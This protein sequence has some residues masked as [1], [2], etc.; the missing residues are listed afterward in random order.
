MGVPQIWELLRPYIK[1]KRLPLKC[2]VSD[3]KKDNGR[4]P[5]I[6]IDGYSWIF[7]CGFLLNQDQDVSNKYAGY[8]T[9]PKAL[10]N[11]LSRLK[12]FLSLD[13][14]FILVFDGNMKPWFKN[15]YKNSGEETTTDTEYAKDYSVTWDE[16][17]QAHQLL[18]SC[19]E[20]DANNPTPS[21]MKIIKYILDEMKISYIEAC[22]EG[23]AQCAWLQKHNYVDYVLSND[24]DTLIFGCSKMLRNY[25]KSWEDVG[26]TGVGNHR[27]DRKRDNKETFVTIVDIEEID[28]CAEERYNWWSLLFFSV[29][30][31]ADYNKGV[32]G[33]GKSKS[34]KLAQLT[35][36]DFAIQFHDIFN[37]I[38]SSSKERLIEYEQ[39]KKRL[40]DYC[41]SHSVELF[42]RNYK[43]LLQEDMQ[44]WPSDTAIMYYF[45]PFLIPDLDEGVMDL[46]NVN[47]SGSPSYENIDFAN[48]KNYLSAF[49]LPGVTDFERWFFE[50]LQESF[51]LRH[52]LINEKDSEKYMKITEEKIVYFSE[53]RFQSICWKVRYNPYIKSLSELSGRLNAK[54]A[55]SPRKRSPTKRQLESEEHWYG[56]WVPKGLIPGSHSLVKRF[57]ERR[58]IEQENQSRTKFSPKKSLKTHSQKNT[59][60]GFLMCHSSPVQDINNLN[61]IK[62]PLLQTVKKRLFVEQEDDFEDH[63]EHEGSSLIILEEIDVSKNDT[64]P[65]KQTW[66]LTQEYEEIHSDNEESPI[67]KQRLHG[68]A[69]V[70]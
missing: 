16:H 14:S 63:S 29:L 4:S 36:P 60:D 55:S 52:L 61:T 69:D 51:I 38:E 12:E 8:G 62:I 13:I 40:F 2:F 43:T 27:P 49:H 23:E 10:V 19:M 42:G 18:H 21:F 66:D 54:K 44:G 5:R 33:L 50:I 6:A 11:F 41:K 64:S 48:L 70:H 15:N 20:T 56:V 30:L 68:S 24:S 46:R 37:T 53:N 9:I 65:S 26:A 25:S 32:K 59:L 57:E 34:A 31:G 1:D 67:K 47:M 7:E 28:A 17:M 3:F 39:F 35:S 45:H 58:K 22:G